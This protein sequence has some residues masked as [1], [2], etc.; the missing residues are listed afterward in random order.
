MFTHILVPLDGSIL[1]ECVVPHAI[2]L[3][4]TLETR[5]TLLHVLEQPRETG[6]LQP[7]DPVKW[8]LKKHDAGVYLDGIEACFQKAGL[9]VE[10]SIQ[11]GT[12][13]ERIIDYANNNQ[14]DLIVLSTHGASGLSIWNM[15]SVVQK[16]ILRA[17]K[18]TLLVRPHPS[19]PASASQEIRYNRLFI[20][21]DGSARAELI[22]PVAIR[23]ANRY[24]S[25]LV[26]GTVVQKPEI[27]NRL[28]ISK[29][30]A[31]MI[32]QIVERNQKASAH[33]LEQLLA[34]LSQTDI[35]IKTRLIVSE[36]KT[37]AL[38]NMVETENADMVLLVAHGHS[39]LGR[40]P[41]GSVATSFIDYGSTSLLIIQDLPEGDFKTINTDMATIENQGH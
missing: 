11:D 9:K 28:P 5:V 41:Y 13:A 27:M 10:K 35:E 25:K 29:E 6:P 22:L 26:I 3:A 1:A 19:P 20:G 8:H 30:D 33:Y 36:N 32:D 39:G 21:L 4:A 37:A 31:Q 40:W 16:I 23:I 18:S 24:K 38:H 15:S 12:A 7:I 17:N 14:V 2:S 34:Q